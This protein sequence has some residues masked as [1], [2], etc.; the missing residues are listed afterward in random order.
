MKLYNLL[1]VFLA[2]L[3]TLPAQAADPVA[4]SMFQEGV[5]LMKD[6]RFA[7]ACPKLEASQ[8]LEPK[9]GTL[10]T[11]AN[12]S[13]QIGRTATAWAQ[14]KEAAAL[15]RKEDREDYAQKATDLASKLEPKLSKLRIDAQVNQGGV[16][17]TVKLDGKTVL[18][19]TFGVAFAIDPG[20]HEIEASAPGRK[21]WHARVTIGPRA[22]TKVVAVPQLEPASAAGEP[23]PEPSPKASPAPPPDPPPF[24]GDTSSRTVPVW[25]WI[26]GAVGLVAIGAAIAF[27]IDQGSA[28]AALDEGCGGEARDR[29]PATYDFAGDRAREERDFALFVGL[30]VA[31]LVGVGVGVAGIA[32]GLSGNEAG[33]RVT[34]IVSDRVAG[35]A[36]DITF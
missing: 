31:G 20:S 2:V 19:G 18:S 33:G 7:D 29:C 32:L 8:K 9:S 30:G 10:L 4:E 21:T 17:L 1:V 28:A 16:E 15:A 35:V 22:D 24:G 3:F 11:L 26:A 12:C 25:A 34:P 27:K 14:Y 6:G 23:P 13:E 5:E 36:V